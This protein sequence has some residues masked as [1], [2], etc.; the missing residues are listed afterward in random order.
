MRSAVL[1]SLFV[2]L[3][4]L[5]PKTAQAQAGTGFVTANGPRLEVDGKP[6]LLVGMN[7]WDL[8]PAKALAGDITGC[9]YQHGD[10]DAYLDASFKRIAEQTHATVVRTFGFQPMYTAGGLD[11]STTDKLLWYARRYGIRLIPV[12]GNQYGICGSPPKPASWYSS[13]YRIP[14]P[15]WGIDYRSYAIALA[16]RYRDE[17]GIAF[18]QLMNEADPSVAGSPPDPLELVGFARDMVRAI[19]DEAGDTNHLINLGTKGGNALGNRPPLYGWLLDCGGDGPAGCTDL[20]EVHEHNFFDELRGSPLLSLV[21]V[22][23]EA[24]NDAGARATLATWLANI[25]TWQTMT[26]NVLP[27]DPRYTH[28]SIH[29]SS[30]ATRAFDVFLDAVSV[31]TYD[32]TDPQHT[33]GFESGTDGFTATGATLQTTTRKAYTG[34]AALD[35]PFAEADAVHDVELLAPPQ[36]DAGIRQLVFSTWLTFSAPAADVAS[37]VSDLHIATIAHRKPFFEGEAGI[38]A[39]V[40]GLGGCAGKR[41]LSD[42]AATFDRML[43]VQTDDEHLASGII[44]WDWKDPAVPA[45]APDGSTVTDPGFDCWAVTPGDPTTGVLRTWADRSKA[46]P[47]P[48][49]SSRPADTPFMLILEPPAASGTVGEEIGFI[50][51]VTAGGNALRGARVVASG[52]CTGSTAVD[53]TGLARARCRIGVTGPSTIAVSIDPSSCSCTLPAHE[54]PLLAK[55]AV[56]LSA[57]STVGANERPATVTVRVSST[58]NLS[59]R[60]VRW[61]LSECHASGEITG[62]STVVDLPIACAPGSFDG[63]IMLHARTDETSS[64]WSADLEIPALAFERLYV[65]PGTG[66]CVGLSPS[67]SHVGATRAPGRCGTTLFGTPADWMT[68]TGMIAKNAGYAVAS[69][70]LYG[71]SLQGVFSTAPGSNAFAAVLERDGGVR[72]LRST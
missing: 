13:G 24:W 69:A 56:E 62:D 38:E 57:T 21:T 58:A 29:L 61:A 44:V 47:P 18:W 66:E 68:G 50:A 2:A 32:A 36:P 54:F 3:A 71:G 72:V 9:Y 40:P 64:L 10:L 28:F 25:E 12:I 67:T 42:R 41:S 8:D 30:P 51:R 46:P 20:A 16:S 17:P 34:S 19:R 27:Q 60:G 5:P 6:F 49:P 22:R 52:G 33:Y 4:A 59:L 31:S 14:E 37:V 55:G 26:V 43:R 7:L 15:A 65:D 70:S 63:P 53:A 45:I 23:V 35:V 39:Q 1:I 48:A 11:W